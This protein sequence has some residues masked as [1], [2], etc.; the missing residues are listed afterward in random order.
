MARAW[1]EPGNAF[2]QAVHDYLFLL[3]RGYPVN[4]SLKLVGDRHRLDKDQRVT[5]FR[6]V[7]PSE[8]SLKLR[9]KL[10]SSLPGAARVALDGYNGP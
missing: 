8:Q 5:L 3:D 6:G 1:F 2:A 10:L 4:A 9:A 7:L